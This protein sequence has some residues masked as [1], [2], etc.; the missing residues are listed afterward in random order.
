MR[1]PSHN[2][3]P[4]SPTFWYTGVPIGKVLFCR[5]VVVCCSGK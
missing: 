5:C 3:E 4:C 1:L 2:T